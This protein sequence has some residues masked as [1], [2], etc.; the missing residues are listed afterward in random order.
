MGESLVA[1]GAGLLAAALLA[2][3]GRRIGLPT[4]P[5]FMIAGIILGPHTPGIDVVAHPENLRLLAVIGL[6]FLLFNLGL[7]FS[8]DE[9]VAGGP[10]LI[11]AG[12]I[13]LSINVTAGLLV[14]FSYGWGSREALVIAGCVGIGSSAIATKLVIE[15]KRLANPETRII[16]GIA[17]VEDVFLAIYLAVLQPVIGDVQGAGAILA[18]IGKA[19]AFLIVMALVARKGADLV[20]RFID[21]PSEELLTIGFVGLTVL[22]AGIA[23]QLGVS[24]AIGAFMVGLT[25]AV[26]PSRDRIEHLALPLRDTFGAVFFFAFGLSID[27]GEVAAV[28]G[29]IALA[30]GV[31]LVGVFSAAILA[32]RLYRLGRVATSNLATSVLARGEFALIFA[33]LATESGLDVRINALVAG[34]VLVLALGAPILALNAKK[35]ARIIP[36]WVIARRT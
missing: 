20:A 23:A 36:P 11:G 13:F 22:V 5:L 14:G 4:I 25:L 16:L 18:S 19:F 3:A 27:S 35:V 21:T 28:I 31:T 32:G 12:A 6:V 1:L 30:L 9:L 7:E 26:S 33:A 34:Y 15:L 10:R 17:V 8:V 2:R 24:E 29:P